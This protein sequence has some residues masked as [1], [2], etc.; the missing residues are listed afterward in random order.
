[1]EKHYVFRKSNYD[2]EQLAWDIEDRVGIRIMAYHTTDSVFGYMSTGGD[3]IRVAI[4]QSY[5]ETRQP[6]AVQQLGKILTVEQED[7]LSETIAQHVPRHRIY[8][9]NLSGTV[10]RYRDS[11]ARILVRN[12]S[13]GEDKYA[14]GFLYES[15]RILFTAAHVVDSRHF[16]VLGI[17]FPKQRVDGRIVK[18]D[19]RH[20]MAMLE[21]D[22]SID[23]SPLRVRHDLLI[24]DHLGTSCVV[25][26]YPDIPGMEPSPSFY[27]V[28]PVSLK[29]N[30]V[31]SQDLIELSTH[32][33]SGC[34]GAPV[35]TANHSLIGMVIG[36]PSRENSDDIPPEIVWPKWTPGAVTC[37]EVRHWGSS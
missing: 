36:Y 11:V 27:K 22:K 7:L 4:Y 23:A 21:L 14:S 30:Y 25:I 16:D 5:R 15:S 13:T 18:I 26:G 37:N 29:H 3:E 24:P 10:T 32:L 9:G 34:S 33:G 20:D 1:M 8:R 17:E 12:R 19:L 28:T 31:M 35:V 6:S 2:A